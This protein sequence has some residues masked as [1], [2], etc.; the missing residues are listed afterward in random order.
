MVEQIG[1]L[2]RSRGRASGLP[3]LLQPA[4]DRADKRVALGAFDSRRVRQRLQQNR[5]RMLAVPRNG[6]A[7]A[8]RQRDGVVFADIDKHSVGAQPRPLDR[9]DQALAALIDPQIAHRATALI[10]APFVDLAA[11]TPPDVCFVKGKPLGQREPSTGERGIVQRT[12]RFAN[13]GG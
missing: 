9:G 2:V 13:W 5:R 3:Q 12:V 6:A 8:R 11:Q 1:D 7:A 10:G 4:A